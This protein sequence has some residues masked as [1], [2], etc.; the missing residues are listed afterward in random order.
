VSSEASR[1][2]FA[3][4]SQAIFLWN[5]RQLPL[6]AS[7]M[8]IEPKSSLNQA[9]GK[10]TMVGCTGKA[11]FIGFSMHNDCAL[12][13]PREGANKKFVFNGQSTLLSAV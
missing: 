2:R 9:S 7:T 6:P 4:E 12:E 5:R 10:L 13:E 8:L 1:V 3:E 11:I